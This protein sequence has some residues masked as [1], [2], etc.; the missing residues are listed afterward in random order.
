MGW[1]GGIPNQTVNYATS[2]L[3]AQFHRVAVDNQQD[4]L[5][6][7]NPR[8]HSFAHLSEEVM[9]FNLLILLLPF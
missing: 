9:R 1:S 4:K 2:L 5:I 3:S 6:F 8:F 7:N